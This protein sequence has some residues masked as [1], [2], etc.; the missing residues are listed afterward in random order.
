MREPPGLLKLPFRLARLQL[1]HHDSADQG[2]EN[3]NSGGH[4]EFVPPGEFRCTIP[5]RV[6][7]RGD[8]FVR[9]VPLKIHAERPNAWVTSRRLFPKRLKNNGVEIPAKTTLRTRSQ[10]GG[11]RG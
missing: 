6:F 7:A 10:G 2:E 3:K 5:R 1:S 4:P 8:G 11:T 9:E